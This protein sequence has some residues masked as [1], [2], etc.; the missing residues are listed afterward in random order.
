MRPRVLVLLVPVALFV[1][2]CSADAQAPTWTYAPA[3]SA[4]AVA[5]PDATPA[6]TVEPTAA[7]SSAPSAVPSAEPLSGQVEVVMSDT[8]RFAPDPISVKAGEDI[9]FVVV[10]EGV[11]VHEFFVGNED[12]QS[13]HAAEMAAGGSH[14][15][16]NA[17]SLSAGE[18]GTLTMTFEKAGSLL[19]GCHEPG[20]YDA[21]MKATLTVV[22]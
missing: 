3:A 9:T 13:H 6:P 1:G 11:I 16:D 7:P 2:A 19:I 18:T 20:H 4:A 8:M 21:G 15:H 14:G 12:E 10:N 22:D 17:L 5:S